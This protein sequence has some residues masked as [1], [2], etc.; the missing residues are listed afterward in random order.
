MMAAWMPLFADGPINIP[1]SPFTI[2]NNNNLFLEIGWSCR[3]RISFFQGSG[4]F[5][6]WN[7]SNF[8]LL[9]NMNQQQSL[10]QFWFS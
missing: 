5:R 10:E 8:L 9:D 4:V 3:I 6:F 7:L 2:Q 1:N